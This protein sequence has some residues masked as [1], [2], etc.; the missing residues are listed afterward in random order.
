M[1]TVN[2]NKAPKVN[3]TK[4]QTVNLTKDGTENTSTLTKVFFGAKW[5]QINHSTVKQVQKKVLVG[6]E[7]PKGFFRKLF[8]VRTPIYETRT[9]EVLVSGHTE[10][11][12]LD[13]SLLIYNEKYSLIDTVYFGHKRSSD[14]SISHSGDD[15]HGTAGSEQDS[16]NETISIDLSK[17]TPRA[18]FIVA[19]LNSFQHH[20]F[21]E[22][23]YMKLRIYT[24]KVGNPDEVLC[25]YNLENNA[26]FKG[27]EAIVLGYFYRSD[28]GWKFKA[29]G[30]TSRG[31]S[32]SS[33]SR[34]TALEVIRKH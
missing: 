23:P 3:L 18:K 12:D 16:D 14:G 8:G 30:T 33:I 7:E 26:T 25:A 27:K 9:E 24:G 15:L 1:A 10:S 6:T 22:I 20:K 2:L 11:V 4:G 31:T 17:V 32:I 13:A 21:D 34:G 19:I 28:N 5:G 29:D